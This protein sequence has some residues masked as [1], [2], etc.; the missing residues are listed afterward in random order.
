MFRFWKP[1]ILV[2]VVLLTK[3]DDPIYQTRLTGF[4]R[5]SICFSKFYL[6]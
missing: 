1:D 4:G 6:L 3:P 2:F 5:L